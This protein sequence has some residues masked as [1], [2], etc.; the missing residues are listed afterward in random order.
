MEAMARALRG[1]VYL[2]AVAIASPAWAEQQAP[3][4][5]GEVATRV[6]RPSLDLPKALRHALEREIATLRVPVGTSAP[7]Y[8]L[9]ASLVKLGL[10]TGGV[11]LG[12][13]C[14]VSAVLREKKSGAIR[15]IVTGRAESDGESPEVELEV[16]DAAVRGAVA[17]VPAAIR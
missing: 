9:S 5:L 4:T 17:S 2:A 8:V 3:V 12:V 10:R 1:A 14:T 6:T 15:A 7:S 11:S 16:L 13:Q